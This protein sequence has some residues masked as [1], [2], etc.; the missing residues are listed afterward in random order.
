MERTQIYL[1]PAQRL[2]LSAVARTKGRPVA[3]I[4]REAV[5]RYLDAEARAIGDDDPLL[6]MVGAGAGL[7]TARDVSSRHHRRLAT[8]DHWR[9]TRR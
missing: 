4:I 7:E 5:D 6:A 2:R 3:E 8:A 1:E 9:R